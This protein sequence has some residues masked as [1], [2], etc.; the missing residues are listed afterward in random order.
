MLKI[1]VKQKSTLVDQSNV[2]NIWFQW[3]DNLLMF[4]LS[5]EP[6]LL[7][8]AFVV[9]YIQHSMV[10]PSRLM[11]RI[12]LILLANK[13]SV[14]NLDNYS[15]DLSGCFFFSCTELLLSI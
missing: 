7:F 14:F 3:V 5:L 10:P 6:K 1:M 15:N 13:S 2:P 9:D 11:L 12:L 4:G 8:L